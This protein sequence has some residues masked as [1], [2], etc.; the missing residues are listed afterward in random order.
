M[1]D[2]ISI[3]GW[4]HHYFILRFLLYTAGMIYDKGQVLDKNMKIVG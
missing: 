4:C 3:S 2:G 1:N